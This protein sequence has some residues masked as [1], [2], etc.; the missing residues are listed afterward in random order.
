VLVHVERAL[1][2]S[3]IH[4]A[5]VANRNVWIDELQVRTGSPV[6]LE[7][8]DEPFGFEQVTDAPGAVVTALSWRDPSTS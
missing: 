6:R 5:W 3:E 8:A 7:N 4:P 1:D 2:S